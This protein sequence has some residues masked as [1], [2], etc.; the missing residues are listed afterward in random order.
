[1]LGDVPVVS[2][3]KG[4]IDRTR[5]G[6]PFFWRLGGRDDLLAGVGFSGNGV[7]PSHVGGRILASLALGR[8]DEW[9]R[10]GL[11]RDPVGSFPPE[12]VRHVG[13]RVIRAAV[14]R[15]EAA[16]D[17]GRKPSWL[18]LK[19]VSLAPAGLVPLKKRG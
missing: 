6:L 13:G 5:T 4:P 7:G 19:L 14:A 17:A 3:W 9:S 16:E 2:D 18:D 10:A 8:D 11:V 1:M 12:P 15:K